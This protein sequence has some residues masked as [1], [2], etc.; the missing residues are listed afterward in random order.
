VNQLRQRTRNLTWKGINIGVTVS[1]L[2]SLLEHILNIPEEAQTPG[3]SGGGSGDGASSSSSDSSS[4]KEDVSAMTASLLSFTQLQ[5]EAVYALVMLSDLFVRDQFEWMYRTFKRM[6]NAIS[7]DS[8]DFVLMSNLVFGLLKCAA[9]L[10]MGNVP[11]GA[12]PEVA[13]RCA[14]EEKFLQDVV[15]YAFEPHHSSTRNTSI[16]VAGV[17]GVTYLISCKTVHILTQPFIVTLARLLLI[18]LSSASTYTISERTLLHLMSCSFALV[19][20]F[21]KECESISFTRALLSSLM[22]RVNE[23]DCSIVTAQA[24]YKCM[25]NLLTSQALTP[26]LRSELE[27]FA[28]RKLQHPTHAFNSVK[29]FFALGL[30][31]SSMYCGP[32][33]V[34]STDMTQSPVQEYA[35]AEMSQLERVQTLFTNLRRGMFSQH[36]PAL[37]EIMALLVVDAF[38]PDQALSFILGEFAKHRANHKTVA[39]IMNRVFELMQDKKL[40]VSWVAICSSSFLQRKTKSLW[41]LACVL[42]ACS[43]SPMLHG[44]FPLVV[45]NTQED[46]DLFVLACSEFLCDPF[47]PEQAC[48]DLLNAI[49]SHSSTSPAAVKAASEEG[50]SDAKT[51]LSTCDKI[52]AL[53]PQLKE[54]RISR[55]KHLEKQ[56]GK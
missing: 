37:I 53:A 19:T 34:F 11:A 20:A 41:S 14:A 10:D 43:Q 36:T 15:K 2:F 33:S 18:E 51:L 38:K 22:N 42:L 23:R 32:S 44:L 8:T 16:L 27:S 12:T 9:V 17:V 28:L 47:V 29:S 7:A 56:E 5:A 21:P 4:Q 50:G 45:S 26:V 55:Q 6:F 25:S 54:I 39:F 24:A 3:A 49:K 40:L 35:T 13:A 52:C 31:L 1:E 46:P 30:L 48:S